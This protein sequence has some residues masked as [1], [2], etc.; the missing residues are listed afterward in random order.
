MAQWTFA[1]NTLSLAS[2]GSWNTITL[3][4]TGGQP[5]VDSGTTMVMLRVWNNTGSNQSIGVRPTGVTHYYKQVDGSAYTK[6][7]IDSTTFRG[8]IYASNSTILLCPV[9]ALKQIDVYYPAAN[10]NFYIIG[11]WKGPSKL[12]YPIYYRPTGTSKETVSL[13]A[14]LTENAKFIYGN[15]ATQT[16]GSGASKGIRPYTSSADTLWYSASATSAGFA[17]PV[18]IDATVPKVE[19]ISSTLNHNDFWIFAYDECSVVY[20]PST[21]PLTDYLTD[22]TSLGTWRTVTLD[23]SR[24]VEGNI[25]AVSGVVACSTATFSFRHPTDAT[26]DTN[27]Y[28]QIPSGIL[29]PIP[30]DTS[31]FPYSIEYK[32]SST[33]ARFYTPYGAIVEADPSGSSINITLDFNNAY[34][35][36]NGDDTKSLFIVS[37]GSQIG[38]DNDVNMFSNK[39]ISAALKLVE[40]LS[41][42]RSDISI[43]LPL[44]RAELSDASKIEAEMPSPPFTVSSSLI[45]LGGTFNKT[46]KLRRFSAYLDPT[47]V[48]T[49]YRRLLKIV[50]GG[51]AIKSFAGFS[52]SMSGETSRLNSFSA[53]MQL[54]SFGGYIFR[55]N[56][57]LQ[58]SVELLYRLQPGAMS[59]LGISDTVGVFSGEYALP[60]TY[61]IL[62]KQT[63]KV[64]VIN[65]DNFEITEYDNWDFND[66]IEVDGQYYGLSDSGLYLMDQATDNG[67]NIA[68]HF[69]T[70]KSDL[71]ITNMKNVH[72][73]YLG[74]DGGNMEIELM[75]DN[76]ISGVAAVT[77]PVDAGNKRG[78]FGRGYKMKYVGVRTRNV[79][80]SDFVVDNLEMIVSKLRRR[81]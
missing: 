21:D 36:L 17:C 78:R 3:D 48:T 76:G 54:A 14:Y 72:D 12:E 6:Y 1:D 20:D 55:G 41:G 38:M 9:S 37:T 33:Y 66:I 8:Y 74:F 58:T 25:I 50:S 35:A 81:I 60:K 47:T 64:V 79:S 45:H 19:V 23:S 31:S 77:A 22:D 75:I 15:I 24:V 40:D 5:S 26:D 70:I 67:T 46:F 43:T 27:L 18:T 49:K 4:G 65:L 10:V 59:A 61:L 71:T 2:A 30:V 80:G 73:V 32:E 56:T 52:L 7:A 16:S 62:S 57:A 42:S 63:S 39:K 13:N 34:T 29:I 28:K 51:S 69:A 11:A 44:F 68:A 53:E